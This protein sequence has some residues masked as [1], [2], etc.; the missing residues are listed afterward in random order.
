MKKFGPAAVILAVIVVVW[1]LLRKTSAVPTVQQQPSTSSSGLPLYTAPAVQTYN[2][3][4]ASLAPSPLV[5]LNAPAVAGSPGQV[6][7]DTGAA[8]SASNPANY[9]IYNLS[10]S[11]AL[12]KG[13]PETPAGPTPPAPASACGCGTCKPACV[14]NNQQFQDGQQAQCMASTKKRQID[15]LEKRYPGLWEALQANLQSGGIDVFNLTQVY[16][17]SPSTVH[18]DGPG[19][20][21]GIGASTAGNSRTWP[22]A[23][24]TGIVG[25]A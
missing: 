6:A 1:L 5:S 8:G 19:N 15:S 24:V 13:K 4:P 12:N 3:T 23:V 7:P 20:P 16:Q 17:H 21:G 18:Q 22:G 11:H 14:N 25:H 9:L 2:V 10:P